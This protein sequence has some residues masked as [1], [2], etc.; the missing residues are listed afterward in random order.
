MTS[1]YLTTEQA[2]LFLSIS[3]SYLH[4]LRMHNKGPAY[5]RKGKLVRY[6]PE[7]LRNWMETPEV[8]HA[9]G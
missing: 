2:A 6:R 1:E 3:E 7:D 4:K 5:I 8:K 9:A